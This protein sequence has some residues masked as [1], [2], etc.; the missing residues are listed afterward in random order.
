MAFDPHNIGNDIT[1]ITMLYG[2]MC[3]RDEKTGTDSVFQDSAPLLPGFIFQNGCLSDDCRGGRRAVGWVENQIQDV[4]EAK[5][6]VEELIL[7]DRCPL[8][9]FIV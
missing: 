8:R 4:G 7:D 5:A 6:A 1:D 3:G 9:Y 2:R